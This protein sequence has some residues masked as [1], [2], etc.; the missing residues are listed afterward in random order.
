MRCTALIVAA[1]RG[2]R[3][4]GEL[5][6][7]Y[8]R[9]AGR[10]VL[11]RAV[12]ALRGHAAVDGVRVVIDPAHRG[13]Y[14]EAVAGLELPP[15]V[16]GGATRQ[17]SVRLGLEALAAAPPH[18]VL[19]HDAARP[20]VSPALI[21]RVVAA[22]GPHEAV[23]PAL[24]VV[25]TLKRVAGD[26]VTGEQ[27]REGLARAQTP[28]GFR[29]APILAAH[30]AM[31]GAALTDDTALA[32]AVG[33][34]VHTVLGEERNLKITTAADLAE[35]EARLAPA[36]ASR[37]GIGFDVHRLVPGRR[38]LLGGVAIPHELGAEGHSDADVALHALTDALLG[39][40]AAGDIGEHFPPTDPRWKD[41]DSA[42]FLAHARDLVTAAGGRIEHVDLVILCERPKVAPHR[43][44]MRARIAAILGIEA[45]R[46]SV[47]ATT[48]ERLGFLG[49]EEGIAAQAVATVALEG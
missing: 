25:D 24:P 15:A 5:P 45:Q 39:A 32:S 19:I 31:A 18:D 21:D 26:V 33:I 10:P 44:A 38:L 35:A 13:L 22:L 37:T 47:K 2:S 16:A 23:L 46:V 1:G 34:P 3:F 8:A 12:E 27:P 28:Q 30:R 49:R 14:E 40:I 6:K 20:L 36:R 4:G 41:A 29:Y 48:T 7:Q 17:D 42:R 43:A 9:L 11:R